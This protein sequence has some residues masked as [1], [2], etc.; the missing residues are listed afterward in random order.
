MRKFPK[1]LVASGLLTLSVALAGCQNAAPGQQGGSPEAALQQ[2]ISKLADVTSYTYAAKVKADLTGPAG[3]AP[4]KIAFN[5]NLDGNVEVKDS[6]DPRFN[7]KMS[8]NMMA[9]SDG[10]SADLEFRLNKEAMFVNLLKLEGQG[11]VTIPA[12]MKAQLIG[13][14]WTLPIPPEALQEMAKS[15]PQGGQANLTE[16]QKKVKVLVEQTKFF[17]NVEFKGTENVG[18]EMSNHYTAV[19]DKDAFMGFVVKMAELQNQPMSEAD[20]SQMKAGMANMEF[21]GHVYVGQN[22]GVLNKVKGDLTFKDASN[23]NSPSGTVA[24]ELMLSDL[25]KPVAVEVPAGAQP[26]PLEAL[27]GFG[28]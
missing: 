20:Q 26:V 11:A 14:W 25:N 17:K 10:G 28:L 24:M 23:A 3:E 21:N 27:G 12:E 1:I 15:L 5:L 6:T 2:G 22:S 9:D 13:K 18:G 19:F 7:L 4:Q 8:G 16:E